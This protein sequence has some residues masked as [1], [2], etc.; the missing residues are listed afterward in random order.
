MGGRGGDEGG[1]DKS[2]G[3]R[4]RGKGEDWV[5]TRWKM[6]VGA[7]TRWRMSWPLETM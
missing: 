5:R 4:R 6:G 7:R 3:G 2:V 1:Q